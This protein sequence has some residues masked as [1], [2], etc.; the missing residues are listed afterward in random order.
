MHPILSY[1][2]QYLT[3]PVPGDYR[4]GSGAGTY[5]VLT[6][7]VRYANPRY[8]WVF[9]PIF[10]GLNLGACVV[11]I[12]SDLTALCKSNKE[13][14]PLLCQCQYRGWPGARLGRKKEG[15]GKEAMGVYS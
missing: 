5:L 9:M 15:R 14:L 10:W 6:Y 2:I 1:P 12:P 13:P 3:G 4:S 7:T 11:C 8:Q